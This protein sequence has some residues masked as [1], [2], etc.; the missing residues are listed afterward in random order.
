MN[1]KITFYFQYLR[2][3]SYLSLLYRVSKFN[4]GIT[5]NVLYHYIIIA[6]YDCPCRG[7]LMMNGKTTTGYDIVASHTLLSPMHDFTATDCKIFYLS[8]SLCTKVKVAAASEHIPEG[9]TTH[10]HSRC[11]SPSSV[12]MCAPWC[13]PL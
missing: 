7:I 10:A 13:C 6:F 8:L 4:N 11:S 1:I 5:G 12:S 2:E 9:F 3:P